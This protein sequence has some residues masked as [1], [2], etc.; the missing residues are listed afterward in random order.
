MEESY[1]RAAD[2][3][4]HSVRVDLP[5]DPSFPDPQAVNPEKKGGCFRC[6]FSSCSDEDEKNI[7]VDLVENSASNPAG[8]LEHSVVI[9][10]ESPLCPSSAE[11][12]F[13]FSPE[14]DTVLLACNMLPAPIEPPELEHSYSAVMD[15]KLS[16]C[17][18]L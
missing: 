8:P 13:S 2:W 15:P 3:P 11:G 5:V 17:P 16:L 10:L 9:E 4:E 14:P 7:V 18:D 1:S 12:E 6:C